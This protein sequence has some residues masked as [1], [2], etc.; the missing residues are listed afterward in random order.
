MRI[1][2]LLPSATEIL[3]VL[4]LDEQVTGVTHECDYPAA[5]ANKPRVTFSLVDSDRASRDIDAQV[6][7]RIHQGQRLYGID[8]ERLLSDPP[9]LIVT[10]DLCPVCAISP[11]DFAGHLEVSGCQARVICLNPNL[12]AD[13]AG[14]HPPDS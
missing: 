4:G 14:R 5:A 13:V 11:S 2:S 10:Q 7:E 3:F 9:D 12:L 1:W 8:E 6:R